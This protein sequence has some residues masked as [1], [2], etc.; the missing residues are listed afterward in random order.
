[1]MQGNGGFGLVTLV[2]HWARRAKLQRSLYWLFFGLAC[3]LG[4]AL[5][6][7]IA[8]RVWPLM[9][10]PTLIALAIL[11]ALLGLLI[12]LAWPWVRA[13][14]TKPLA[15]ARAFD[16]L[17]GLRQRIST[18]LEVSEGTLTIKNDA[19]RARQQQDAM[20]IA[21]SVDAKKLLPLRLRWRDGLVALGLLMAL[22]LALLLPNPQQQVLAEQQLFQENLQKQV[23][24][25]E[26]AKQAIQNS[27]ELTEEQKKQAL[28]ALNEAQQALQES[29][30][31]PEKA[32]AAIN[33]AQSKLDALQDQEALQRNA[34]LEQAGR[35]LSPDE[36]TNALA[37]S[38][39]NK[40]FQQAAQAMRNLSTNNGQAL[41]EEE[42]Q[43]IANQLDQMARQVQNSDPTLAQKLREAAQQMRQGNTQAAQQALN[44]AANSLDKAQQTQQASNA[45]DQ[46]QSQTEQARQ[47]VARANQQAGSQ[48]GQHQGQQNQQGANQAGS[49]SQSGDSQQEGEQSS[50]QS[51]QADSQGMGQQGEAGEGQTSQGQAS[52][53]SVGGNTQGNPQSGHNEDSGTDDSVYAPRRI[54]SQGQQVVLDDTKGETAP[55]PSGQKNIAPDG[56][57]SVAYQQV[58]GEYSKAADDAISN[59]EVPPDKRDYVRDYFSSLDPQRN[60]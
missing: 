40:D 48:S 58:Y 23:E 24:Q 6:L 41:T 17:F 11:F 14:R 22:V 27:R 28:E 36:L 45:L 16:N 60:K 42:A 26:Q 57:S 47:S 7:A 30:T 39:A 38:L 15:W 9:A 19:I 55:N 46:A 3:G 8:A 37:S 59:N 18:A 53:S 5:L 4:M 12:A 52:S 2:Q 21:E 1:M 34:D 43:R 13:I 33:D 10:T 25:I 51:G 50:T 49:Q 29:D 44:E 56:Q 35:S 20:R 54:N 32:L 31:T